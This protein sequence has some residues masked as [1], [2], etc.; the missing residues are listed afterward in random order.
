[1]KMLRC[2]IPNWSSFGLHYFIFRA[3]DNQSSLLPVV[4]SRAAMALPSCR[5]SH[6]ATSA[7]SPRRRSDS[8]SDCARIHSV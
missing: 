2:M 7:S 1:M 4:S 8:G 5:P 6:F 3:L